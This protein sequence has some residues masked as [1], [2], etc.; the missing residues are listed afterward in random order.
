MSR[1]KA[2]CTNRD[3]NI[4]STHTMS[5]PRPEIADVKLLGDDGVTLTTPKNKIT[6]RMLLTHTSGFTCVR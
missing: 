5:F 1:L 6:L 4:V 2:S 3:R